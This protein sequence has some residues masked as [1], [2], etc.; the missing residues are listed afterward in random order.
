MTTLP[1]LFEQIKAGIPVFWK[2]PNLLPTPAFSF[3]VQNVQDAEARLKRF[4]PWIAQRFPETAAANGIIESP[5][6]DISP[7]TAPLTQ[8]DGTAI[9]SRLLLKRDDSLPISGSVKARGGIYAVLKHTEN[10]LSHT[11]LLSQSDDYR[12]IAL[13]PIRDFLSGK[14]LAVGSTGN[15][16][17][18]IGIIGAALGYQTSVYISRE[19]REWKKQLLREKGVRVVEEKDY[20]AAVAAGRAESAAD[21]DSFFIDDERSADLYLGYAVAAA[22]LKKQLDAARISVDQHHPLYVMLPCGVGGGPGG[23][24]FGLK[25]IFGRAVHCYFA[26]PVQAPCMLLAMVIMYSLGGGIVNVF[27][28]LTLV[29][30]ANVARVVRA[31]TLQLKN[32]EFVEAA[33]VIGVSR[34]RIMRRHILPNCLPTLLVL[35]TLNIPASILTESSLSFLGLGIQ[36][37]NASWGLM[38]NTGRQYLYNA[39]WLCFAP[40]AAIMLIVLAFNFLGNG[41]LDVLDPRQKKQ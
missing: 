2:N 8:K 11:G 20:E 33:R 16:G 5:L 36:P 27:L 32:S 6:S 35:F 19:A 31:Q 39:P 40:G 24:T 30:W 21:P 15:L 41:L 4:A 22:R 37:P 1:T 10:L 26:E 23:I 3:T 18:S 28:T 38:I 34:D 17:L 7:M 9:H 14:K 25:L 12:K 29:N 13:P